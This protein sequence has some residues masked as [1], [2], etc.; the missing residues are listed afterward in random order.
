MNIPTAELESFTASDAANPKSRRY[1]RDP[2]LDPQLRSDATWPPRRRDLPLS[3][4]ARR[5]LPTV[6]RRIVDRFGPERIVLF[7]SQVSGEAR[8]D[9]DIDLLIVLSEVPDPRTARL[10]IRRALRDIPIAKDIFVTTR[11][12]ADRF[13]SIPGTVLHPALH[14]GAT[15]YVRR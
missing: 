10:E 1:P 5:W 11:E 6:K 3:D 7:G 9:S 4:A 12:R 15:I 8:W 13:G 14:E 2:S